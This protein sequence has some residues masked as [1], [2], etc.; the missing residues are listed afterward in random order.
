MRIEGNPRPPQPWTLRN[1]QNLPDNA[2]ELLK[3]LSIKSG[4][5]L[6]R[7]INKEG[8]EMST[9]YLLRLGGDNDGLPPIIELPKKEG[10]AIGRVVL[11]MFYGKKGSININTEKEFPV[12]QDKEPKGKRGTGRIPRAGAYNKLNNLPEESGTIYN[13]QLYP[14]SNGPV[15]IEIKEQIEEGGNFCLIEFLRRRSKDAFGLAA[16]ALASLAKNPKILDTLIQKLTKLETQKEQSEDKEDKLSW[17]NL[18][19]GDFPVQ[20]IVGGGRF[21]KEG[22]INIFQ[23]PYL[24]LPKELTRNV[25]LL[26]IDGKGYFVTNNKGEIIDVSEL[27]EVFE[28]IN[29][30]FSSPTRRIRPNSQRIVGTIGVQ[31]SVIELTEKQ[32]NKL[33]NNGYSIVSPSEYLEKTKPNQEGKAEM[34]ADILGL[35]AIA[36]LPGFYST[37]K[38]N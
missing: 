33:K 4:R 1:M 35:A 24:K 23:A 20:V 30:L 22:T 19:N 7:V 38:N 37:L 10:E 13:A 11:E 29:V 32:I 6:T 16:I 21:L 9:H 28:D 17:Q 34:H 31:T 25:A 27:R 5:F 15:Q 3:S 26:N 2:K 18:K 14:F 36:L 8:I 12:T